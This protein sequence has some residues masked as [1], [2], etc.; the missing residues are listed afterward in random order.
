MQRLRAATLIVGSAMVTLTLA[1]CRRDDPTALDRTTQPIESTAGI[2]S[3]ESDMR[4]RMERLTRAVA[5]ALA[6]PQVRTSVYED[7]RA[8]R[9]REH[10]LHFAQFAL[11]TDS[12]FSPA[13]TRAA[14]FPQRAGLKGLFDSL[15]DLE[16][17]MPVPEHRAVWKGG[18][19]LL[20]ASALRD[21]EIPVAYDLSGRRVTLSSAE[22][23]PA[24]P[25]LAIVPTETDFSRPLPASAVEPFESDL[26]KWN[27]IARIE[28]CDPADPACSGAPPQVCNPGACMTF[29][30]IPGD[31]EGFLMGG[32]EFEVHAITRPAGSNVGT[33]YRCAGEHAP[34]PASQYDQNG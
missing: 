27:G 26:R 11:A 18:D 34:S 17:Y 29:S 22:V 24:T 4:G 32:P 10:K 2:P 1:S 8:S 20:V 19:N 15:I 9:F 6:D 33:D 28:P 16:F 3:S 13:L 12:R 30:H 23:A 31:Y 14:G 5:L 21:H 25:V 7:L